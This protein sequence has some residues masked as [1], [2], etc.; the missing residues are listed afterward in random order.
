MT[1]STAPS[2]GTASSR[3]A[4]R[5]IPPARKPTYSS[6]RRTWPGVGSAALNGI[7]YYV[8]D[9]GTHGKELWRSDGTPAGTFMV[10]DIDNITPRTRHA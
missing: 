4:R 2:V 8:A 9:D 3:K 5:R 10:K 1:R 7:L 6:S